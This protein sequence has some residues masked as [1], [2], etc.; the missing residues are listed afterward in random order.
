MIKPYNINN[1]S[2]HW[3]FETFE[4][5][6]DINIIKLIWQFLHFNSIMVWI[7]RNISFWPSGIAIEISIQDIFTD[8][9]F[10]V[11]NQFITFTQNAVTGDRAARCGCAVRVGRG[12]RSAA[13]RAEWPGRRGAAARPQRELGTAAAAEQP[14]VQP[15]N[16][17]CR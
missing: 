4:Y 17:R 9:I 2:F 8:S 11:Q 16:F 5:V 13:T 7:E 12:V 10:S 3:T 14:S 15:E 6:P 1:K